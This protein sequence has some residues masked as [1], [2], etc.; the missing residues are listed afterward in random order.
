MWCGGVGVCVVGVRMG[1][2]CGGWWWGPGPVSVSEVGGLV[3]WLVMA[4]L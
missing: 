2:A 1:C 4:S 3:G